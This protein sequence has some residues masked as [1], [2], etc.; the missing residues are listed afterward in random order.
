MVEMA[1]VVKVGASR[2]A[3]GRMQTAPPP[4][5]AVPHVPLTRRDFG[6]A[7]NPSLKDGVE[8]AQELV[9]QQDVGSEDFFA[10]DGEI[11]TGKVGHAA[12][13][14]LY[15]ENSRCGVPGIELEFPESVKPTRS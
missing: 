14:L 13:G 11:A 3:R 8:L 9:M 12:T 7:F 5:A 15:Q 10:V 1:I 2:K 6:Q 4:R